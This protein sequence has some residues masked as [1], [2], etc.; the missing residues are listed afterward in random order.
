MR[1]SPLTTKFVGL[2]FRQTQ[3]RALLIDVR[4]RGD[5][6]LIG[7]FDE[8]HLAAVQRFPALADIAQHIGA[9]A[10]LI[11]HAFQRR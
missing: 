1:L 8:L 9:A 7:V 10:D 11:G 4:Q 3:R 5:H 6:H 2:P